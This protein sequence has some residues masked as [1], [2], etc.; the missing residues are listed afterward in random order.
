MVNDETR[1]FNDGFKGLENY[2][3]SVGKSMETHREELR[4]VASRRVVRS[5]VLEKIAEAEKIEVSAAEVDTEIE[6]MVKEADKQA[7]DVRKLFSLPQARKSIENFLISRKTMEQLKQIASG[8][9]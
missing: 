3:D 6:K 9:V 5:L 2:L 7:D 8:S 1:S 4:P